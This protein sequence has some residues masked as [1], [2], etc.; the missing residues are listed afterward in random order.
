MSIK[1]NLDQIVFASL[2][3]AILVSLLLAITFSI[4]WLWLTAL[5]GVHQ[6]QVAFTSQCYVAKMLKQQGFKTGKVFE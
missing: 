5:I 2:G 3:T 1:L 4:N 6:I